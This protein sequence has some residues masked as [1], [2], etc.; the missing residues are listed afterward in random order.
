LSAFDR[1]SLQAF[2]ENIKKSFARL[3]M[4]KM[5]QKASSAQA[6]K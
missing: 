5:Q 3:R 1:A 2:T 4:E 6:A